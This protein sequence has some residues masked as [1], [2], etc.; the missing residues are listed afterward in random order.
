MANDI[1]NHKGFGCEFFALKAF[2]FFHR[3][4]M[5]RKKE[6]AHPSNGKCQRTPEIDFNEV[7]V[8]LYMHNYLSKAT[9]SQV[10][11]DQICKDISNNG[12]NTFLSFL[13]T[14]GMMLL[15]NPSMTGA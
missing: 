10:A 14:L 2:F 6:V 9:A 3:R 8:T 4:F 12:K 7:R 13:A 15:N 1:F 5:L 11:T